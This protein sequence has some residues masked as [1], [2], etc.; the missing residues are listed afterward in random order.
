MMHMKFVIA[1]GVLAL[2]IGYL[3]LTGMQSTA[4]YYLTVGELKSNGASAIG[5]PVR[6]AGNVAPGSVEK[7]NGGLALQ[8]LVQDES[9]T[10]P[11]VYKG[12]PVP[13]I[14]GEEVQ[15]VVEG[16]V[17]PDGTFAA[18]TL[19]AKCPSKF[20]DGQTAAT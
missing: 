17:Q 5:R 1:G 9:G 12:G 20:E 19:L 6:V 16:K 8:F 7:T 13:D 18:D 4:V 10:F 3:V 15:V 14:F 2:A 11:V